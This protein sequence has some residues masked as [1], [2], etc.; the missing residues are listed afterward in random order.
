MIDNGIMGKGF[1]HM[2]NYIPLVTPAETPYIEVEWK[3]KSM[4]PIYRFYNDYIK[5]NIV[6]NTDMKKL[7]F[8][9]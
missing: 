7:L 1:I 8:V 9:D 6:L 2:S 3:T 5:E 4:P